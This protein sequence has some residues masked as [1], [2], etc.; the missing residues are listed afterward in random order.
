[1]HIDKYTISGPGVNQYY[2]LK[3]FYVV[4]YLLESYARFTMDNNITAYELKKE[5]KSWIVSEIHVELFERPLAWMNNI[6]VELTFRSSQRIKIL[7]DYNITHKGKSIGKATMQ[8]IVLDQ[9]RHRPI[10]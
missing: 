6:D 10:A 3:D 8:W 4:S 7:C 1:M 5:G 9:V 2:E